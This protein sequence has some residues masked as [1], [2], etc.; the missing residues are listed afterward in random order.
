[1]GCDPLL[2]VSANEFGI[3]DWVT[4]GCRKGGPRVTRRWPK[5]HA[6]VAQAMI[7]VTALFAMEIEK[8][9]VGHKKI[10][11]QP[12]RAQGYNLIGRP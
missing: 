4:Q 3:W 10:T 12:K 5:D 11:W 2:M 6:R 8:G 7:Y 1:M 9:R